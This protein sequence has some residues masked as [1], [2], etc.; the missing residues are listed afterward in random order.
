[1]IERHAVGTAKIAPVGHRNA[2]VFDRPL[3]SVDEH[4]NHYAIKDPGPQVEAFSRKIAALQA[5]I[6]LLF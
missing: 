6:D 5:C 2:Q 4:L 1:M 3:I